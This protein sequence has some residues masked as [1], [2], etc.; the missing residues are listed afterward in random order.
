[1]FGLLCLPDFAK[2]LVAGLAF[3]N[4][5]YLRVKVFQLL[6]LGVRWHLV[7]ALFFL[8]RSR[9]PSTCRSPNRIPPCDN[10]VRDQVTLC[11]RRR[12][13]TARSFANKRALR[14]W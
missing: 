13:Q 6:A 2:S 11:L 14:L 5:T 4:L 8:Q 3:P 10:R 12:A 1:M 7:V 9:F